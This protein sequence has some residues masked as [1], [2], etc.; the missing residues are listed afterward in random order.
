MARSPITQRIDEAIDLIE[1]V[2]GDVT[3]TAVQVNAWKSITYADWRPGQPEAEA[4]ALRI[5]R[6]LRERGY[7]IADADTGTRVGFWEC[8]VEQLKE[9]RRVKLESSRYD[10]TRLDAEDAVI[11]LLTEKK[12]EFGY[13]VYPG[14]FASEIDRIYSM[15]G[16]TVPTRLDKAA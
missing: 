6:R 7:Q 14:L 13:E 10:K 1:R 9:Q 16:L 3:P 11:A 12:K 8:T 2:G 5:R 4:L 15:H